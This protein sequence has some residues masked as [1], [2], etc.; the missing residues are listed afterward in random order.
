MF[1][2]L[3]LDPI[4]GGLWISLFLCPF[5]SGSLGLEHHTYMDVGDLFLVN[6][7]GWVL[8]DDFWVLSTDLRGHGGVNTIVRLYKPP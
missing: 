6:D 4:P 8:K 1:H 7:P 3:S 5:I 2:A